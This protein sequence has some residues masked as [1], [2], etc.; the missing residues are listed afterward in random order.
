MKTAA[1]SSLAMAV[2]A[3]AT[4]VTITHCIPVEVPTTSYDPCAITE[5][6]ALASNGSSHSSG[7]G[8]EP[9]NSRE[10]SSLYALTTNKVWTTQGQVIEGDYSMQNCYTALL[11]HD[12]SF[13]L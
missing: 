8:E 11:N 4:F 12:F 2:L 9:E 10:K 13:P 7:S 3:L 5:C 6:P 1:V